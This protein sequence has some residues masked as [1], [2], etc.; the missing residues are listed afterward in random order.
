MANSYFEIVFDNS[1]SMS[2]SLAS[3]TRLQVAKDLFEKDIFPLIDDNSTIAV[4]LLRNSCNGVSNYLN[5]GT[6][7]NQCLSFIRSIQAGGETP[8]FNTM[9]DA[10]ITTLK[11][12]ATDKTIFVLT[13]GGDTCNLSIDQVMTNSE[14]KYFK[15]I[16]VILAQFT[17]NSGSTINQLSHLANT[18]GAKTFKFAS[19]ADASFSSIRSELK[20]AL[21]II[22]MNRNEPLTHCF[23][24][25]PGEMVY[26]KDIEAAGIQLHQAR[27]LYDEHFLSWKPEVQMNVTPLQLAELKFLHGIRFKTGIAVDMMR[28]MLSQL[29]K[30]YY[31]NSNCIYWHF[32]EARWKYFPQPAPVVVEKIVE[33]EN[34]ISNA[35]LFA[36]DK[37]V[38]YRKSSYYI[39]YSKDS[40]NQLDIMPSDHYELHECDR[41]PKTIKITDGDILKYVQKRKKGRPSKNDKY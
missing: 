11:N 5:F 15:Q 32:E 9:K 38:T 20:S 34:T 30:P 2:E 13:D 24:E 19:R 28:S 29:I 26:W 1:T 16:N 17:V 22:G 14:L 35:D 8:L 18:I 41:S 7:K 39:V 40:S 31:Y 3:S 33:R 37:N 6:D 4:R 25:M 21:N 27:V 23:E 36:R 10:L 12:Q